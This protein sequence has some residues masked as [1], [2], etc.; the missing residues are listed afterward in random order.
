MS[1]ATLGAV[2][3]SLWPQLVELIAVLSALLV[4]VC[5][6]WSALGAAGRGRAQ[7]RRELAARRTAA[8]DLGGLVVNPAVE[9]WTAHNAGAPTCAIDPDPALGCGFCAGPFDP[10]ARCACATPCGDS[11]C[12]ALAWLAACN[13]EELEP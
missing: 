5:V 7:R 8:M 13:T 4:I 11:E 12:G 2:I 9:K 6:A 10:S 1:P 3:G